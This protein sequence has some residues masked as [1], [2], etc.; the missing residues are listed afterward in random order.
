MLVRI[1]PSHLSYFG[2]EAAD[3][4]CA[5]LYCNSLAGERTRYGH[6]A[7][8]FACDSISSTKSRTGKWAGVPEL[9]AG[10]TVNPLS[11]TQQVRILH[12]PPLGVEQELATPAFIHRVSS[13]PPG[14]QGL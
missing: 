14:A 7:F 9:E 6:F 8:R 4:G 1:Q 10:R 11:L 12:C 2:S 13:D 3:Q 5:S